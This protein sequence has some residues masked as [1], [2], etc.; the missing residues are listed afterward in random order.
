LLLTIVDHWLTSQWMSLVSLFS[1]VSNCDAQ[2]RFC[3]SV[4]I[5]PAVHVDLEEAAFPAL[6]HQEQ[7]G[8]GDQYILKE[9]A[10]TP[11]TSARHNQHVSSEFAILVGVS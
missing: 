8:D 6:Q 7:H 10:P 1:E 4:F 5:V 3:L 2:H 9:L 11:S